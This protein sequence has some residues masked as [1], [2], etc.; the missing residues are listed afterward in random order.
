MTYDTLHIHIRFTY[1]NY[2]IFSWGIPLLSCYS[3]NTND[4]KTL[5]VQ[6]SWT[7]KAI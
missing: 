1:T 3:T 4:E 6:A 5:I 2:S 7:K